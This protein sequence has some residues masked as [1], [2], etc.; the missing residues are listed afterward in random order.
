[1][2]LLWLVILA[3]AGSL[4]SLYYYLMVVKAILVDEEGA[5]PWRVNMIERMSIGV[6]AGIVL[7]LGLFPGVLLQGIVS[8]L[9]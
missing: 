2:K 9:R 3:L 1:M 8:G 4:V 6:L 7:G 5:G